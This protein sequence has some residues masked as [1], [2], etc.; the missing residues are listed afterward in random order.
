MVAG[1]P[2][3]ELVE[4]ARALRRLADALGV[5][6]RPVFVDAPDEGGDAGAVAALED[7][8][9]EPPFAPL[10]VTTAVLGVDGC[11]SGWVGAVLAP[12]RPRPSVVVAGSLEALVETVREQHPEL[13]VVGVDIPI[14]LPDSGLRA[15]DRL[16][17]QE[18]PGKASSVFTTMTRPAWSAPDRAA[19]DAI[20]RPLTGQGVSA[21][22]FALAPKVLEADRY[23]RSR[24]TVRVL[25][26]HPEV[27]FA[28][29][30]GA[31][32]QPGKRTDEGVAARLDVLHQ[33]GL[34]PPSM[35]SGSGY[36]TDDVLDAVAVAWTAHRYATGAAH[37]LP[38]PPETASDGI[39]AAI[40]V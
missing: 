17:R 36:G 28:A 2:A 26:V 21:Q 9:V 22:S 5:D 3:V 32:V 24:P 13:V 20:N 27:S 38:D 18:L 15:A 37:S 1:D 4:A 7:A 39:A 12:G 19:A 16:A 14:G 30:A 6:L 31:P 8:D 10:E 35:L 34:L 11:R 40:W 25:E 23:V 33:V 29:M